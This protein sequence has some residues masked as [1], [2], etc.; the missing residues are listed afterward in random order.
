MPLQIQIGARFADTRC[1][2]ALEILTRN[3]GIDEI[4]MLRHF[5]HDVD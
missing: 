5:S 4:L 1:L 2:A 3:L